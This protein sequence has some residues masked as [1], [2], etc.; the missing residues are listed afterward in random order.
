MIVQPRAVDEHAE[1][2]GQEADRRA[3]EATVLGRDQL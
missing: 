3:R 2:Q 1:T